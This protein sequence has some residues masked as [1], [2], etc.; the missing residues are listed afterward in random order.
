MKKFIF[1]FLIF[2]AGSVIAQPPKGPVKPGMTFGKEFQAAEAMDI[3]KVAPTLSEEE[4]SVMVEGT[5]TDVC[6]AEGCWLKLQGENGTILVRMR[7][8]AFKVPVAMAGKKI[9]ILGTA[10]VQE[11]SVEMLRHYAEDA[12]KSK[13]E[14][15]SIKEPKQEVIIQADG[16][17]VK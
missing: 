14:I 16:I 7:D 12:G 9:A 3:N 8:H 4:T 6:K 13:E 15:A 11:T 17:L 10:K 1:C 2:C 5:V